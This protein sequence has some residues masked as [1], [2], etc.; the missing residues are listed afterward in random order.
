MAGK[1]VRILL[2]VVLIGF[3][4]VKFLPLGVTQFESKTTGKRFP[5]PSF[6]MPK[7]ECCMYAATFK[8]VRSV[9]SLEQEAARILESDYE[10]LTCVDGKKVYY[11][12]AEDVTVLSY[13][14]NLGFP[15]NELVISYDV[16]K[17]CN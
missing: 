16:G 1:V 8:T 12:A 13:K 10:E 7:D 14:A 4:G 6:M 17:R 3:V 11:N 2:V 15:L 9:W 5:V